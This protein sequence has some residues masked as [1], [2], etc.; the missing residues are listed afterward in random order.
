MQSILQ[1]VKKCVLLS[2]VLLV[3]CGLLYPLALTG[4]SQILLPHQANGSIVEV[5][6][7]AVGSE[8]IGQ[9]FTDARF[10]RGRVSSVGY[11]TYTE[12]DLVPDAEGNT[13]YGGVGSGS[14][15]Y[16]PSN[17][18]L[19]ARIEE[20]MA[21]F[22]AANP[23]VTKEQIPTDLL[24]ASGSGLDPHISPAAATVQ[25]PAI[26]KATGL[27]QAELEKMV[28]AN[29]SGK[30]FGIFGEEKVNVFMTN[31]EIAKALKII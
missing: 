17:P 15:N 22:L 19:I 9:D 4:I 23:D 5:N 21:T 7:V 25:L 13:A 2:L 10:L 29:T 24:T 6:G 3:I 16:A 12:A 18:D 1:T 28:A 11:N 30:V 14:F 31:L 20:D 27:A 8:L 26:A